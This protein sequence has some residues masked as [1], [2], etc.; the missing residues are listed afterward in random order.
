MLFDLNRRKL[1]DKIM[2]ALALKLTPHTHTFSVHLQIRLFLT[3]SLQ[4][5]YKMI[6]FGL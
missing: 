2:Q 6:A 4:L 3:F 5:H 1:D